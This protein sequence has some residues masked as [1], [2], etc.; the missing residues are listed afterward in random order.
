MSDCKE[1]MSLAMQ[2][3]FDRYH[4]TQPNKD[5]PNKSQLLGVYS[6]SVNSCMS[7][8]DVIKNNQ[9]LRVY[10]AEIEEGHSHSSKATTQGKRIAKTPI[11]Q[12]N[13]FTL[14][15]INYFS[16]LSELLYLNS[17]AGINSTA[18][19]KSNSHKQLSLFVKTTI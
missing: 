4:I 2:E 16:L 11:K 3:Y 12:R 5:F 10:E 7:I 15:T 19:N 18:N 13:F 1:A 6:V 9:K 8:R 17:Y 14:T